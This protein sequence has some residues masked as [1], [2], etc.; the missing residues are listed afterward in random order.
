MP[1]IYKILTNS[2]NMVCGLLGTYVFA[3]LTPQIW[4][5][6]NFFYPRFGGKGGV[7]PVV[8]G[9]GCDRVKTSN[10]IPILLYDI[11][12]IHSKSDRRTGIR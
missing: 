1:V 12:N 11:G 6:Q 8:A 5:G 10:T 4:G 7:S 2:Q 9:F 3:P